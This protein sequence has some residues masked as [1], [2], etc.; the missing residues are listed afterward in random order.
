MLKY[1]L[2]FSIWCSNGSSGEPYK[3]LPAEAKFANSLGILIVAFGLVAFGILST[4]KWQRPETH[5]ESV[6]VSMDAVTY[7]QCHQKRSF[8]FELKYILPH[9]TFKQLLESNRICH[10]AKTCSFVQPVFIHINCTWRFHDCFILPAWNNNL[11]VILI[12]ASVRGRQHMRIHSAG[13][14]QR[15]TESPG[16]AGFHSNQMKTINFFTKEI[17]KPCFLLFKN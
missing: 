2:L 5:T 3:S 16:H 10:W 11:D 9:S 12:T 4:N 15:A 6:H 17:R 8:W 14:H 1:E 13:G 7:Y